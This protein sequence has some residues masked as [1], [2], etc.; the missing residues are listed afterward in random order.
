MSP[1]RIATIT[2]DWYPFEP[3]ALRLGQAAADAGYAVDVI[4]LRQPHEKRYDIVNGVH[5]YRLPMS[6]EYSR[7]LPMA[8]LGWCWFLLLAGIT[9]TYLH[10]KHAYDV[11]HVH[12][13][14][15]F[16]VFATLFPRLLGAKIILDV[17]DACPELITEKAHGK[18]REVAILLATWQER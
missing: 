6:R 5:I 17:Q 14:P 13:M 11:I 8:V 15:D 16:L 7:S 3:R 18:L 1:V 12:N 4:C 2:F 9:I 10:L